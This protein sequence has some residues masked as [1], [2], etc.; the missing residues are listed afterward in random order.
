MLESQYSDYQNCFQ[1]ET[2]DPEL[3]E[4]LYLYKPIKLLGKGAFSCVFLCEEK[5]TT[6]LFAIKVLNKETIKPSNISTL[7]K[8]ASIL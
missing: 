5:N 7:I 8:E 3:D 1:S 6:N 2:H 4:F